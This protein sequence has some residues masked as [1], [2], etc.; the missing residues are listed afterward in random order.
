MFVCIAFSF[1]AEIGEK[2]AQSEAVEGLEAAVSAAKKIG[3]PVMI[4]SAYALGG[5][6]SGICDNEA[7]LRDMGRKALSLRQVLKRFVVAVDGGDGVVVVVV[8]VVIWS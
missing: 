3:F 1:F 5:L 7:Q 2:V 8:V 4:R 6:G